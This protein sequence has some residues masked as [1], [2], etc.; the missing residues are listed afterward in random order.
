MFT[1][2]TYILCIL[3]ILQQYSDSDHILTAKEIMAKL[4]VIYDI[5]VDRRTI[6]RNISYLVEFGYD[7]STF[8]ENK[9]G[10]YLREREFE[11]SELHLLADAVVSADFIPEMEGRHLIKK[12]QQLGSSWQTQPLRSLMHV[13]TGK[14]RPNKEIFLSIESLDQA[15]T[16]KKQVQFTYTTYDLDLKLKPRRKEA[17]TVNPYALFWNNGQYYL[18]SNYPPHTGIT[19]FRLDRMKNVVVKEE[20]AAKPP[21]GVDVYD[22]ARQ[23]LFMYGGDL[24]SFTIRCDRLILNDVV[25]RFGDQIMLLSADE[26]SFTTVVKATTGGMRL[27]AIHYLQYCQL[28]EPSWLAEEI[29]TAIR[30]GMDLYQIQEHQRES[31]TKESR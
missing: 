4:K 30:K 2:K 18:I 23:A 28:L 17:Y 5:D 29:R 24:L 16:S 20:A 9:T 21:A 13:K 10:Y 1:E 31:E 8:E 25:D 22:Y 12:L 14:S 6:Y 15:I 19:H 26:E 27:W 7:I 3:K 11:P